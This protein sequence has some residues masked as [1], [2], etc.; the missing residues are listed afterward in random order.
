M[1][2]EDIMACVGTYVLMK[3]FLPSI[4][5]YEVLKF[6]KNVKIFFNPRFQF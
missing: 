2:K 5:N 3:V 6:W 4:D 1:N